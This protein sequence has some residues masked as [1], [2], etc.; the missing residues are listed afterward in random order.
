MSVKQAMNNA[1]KIIVNQKFGNK[2]QPSSPK[3]Y[4]QK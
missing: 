3:G 2:E 1:Y 4:N